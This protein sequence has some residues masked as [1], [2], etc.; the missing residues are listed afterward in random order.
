MS[1]YRA[2]ESQ[3]TSVSVRKERNSASLISP[4]HRELA[5]TS[6]SHRMPADPHIVGG[7]EAS[8]I[9]KRSVRR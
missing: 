5:M 2:F 3:D 1:Y 9:D 4:G 8:R 6:G 7:I